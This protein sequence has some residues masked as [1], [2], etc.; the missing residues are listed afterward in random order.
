[1]RILIPAINNNDPPAAVAL[2]AE[3]LEPEVW[4]VGINAKAYSKILFEYWNDHEGFIVV[5]H[6]IIPWPGALEK[7]WACKQLW[8]G[9]SYPLHAQG[10]F[11]GYL[12][13]TKFSAELCDTYPKVM[14]RAWEESWQ[15]ID[16]YVLTEL[17]KLTGNDCFHLHF[18]PCAHIRE[19]PKLSEMN[20]RLLNETLPPSP[21]IP[22]YYKKLM[23][24]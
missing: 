24:K 10:L 8:C 12:G 17:R 7:L 19:L 3:G 1:M 22:G 14:N 4:N 20:K 23:G 13:C 11:G 9:H 6:D 5:E 18:P 2:R 21:N 16:G 15:K